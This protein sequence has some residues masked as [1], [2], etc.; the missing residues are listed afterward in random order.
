MFRFAGNLYTLQTFRYRCSD[1][2]ALVTQFPNTKFTGD[3]RFHLKRV[4]AVSFLCNFTLPLG[5]F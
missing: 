5:K 3:Y 1:L 4:F 2:V